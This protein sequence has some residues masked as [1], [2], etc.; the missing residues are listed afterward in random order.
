MRSKSLQIR[1]T[2]LYRECNSIHEFLVRK[3][4]EIPDAS[5]LDVLA[6]KIY[7]FK[8][9][10]ENLWYSLWIGSFFAFIII[11][12]AVGFLCVPNFKDPAWFVGEAI[13][14]SLWMIAT[15][16]YLLLF[17]DIIQMFRF[18][19]RYTLESYVISLK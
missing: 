9:H 4:L 5:K 6:C 13:G 3:D 19:Q 14:F 16:V 18:I 10:H 2:K 12:S 8:C 7:D 1:L 15:T 17:A 11:G